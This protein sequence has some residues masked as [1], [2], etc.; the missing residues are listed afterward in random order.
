MSAVNDRT[1]V[2]AVKTQNGACRGP[3]SIYPVARRLYSHSA[4]RM[5]TRGSLSSVPATP[6]PAAACYIGARDAVTYYW[7]TVCQ[8]LLLVAPLLTPSRGSSSRS[9]VGRGR[10]P[11]RPAPPSAAALPPS[12]PGCPPPPPTCFRTRPRCGRTSPHARRAC[13]SSRRR[14]SPQVSSWMRASSSSISAF[15]S[16]SASSL[17]SR[18]SL[19]GLAGFAHQPRDNLRKRQ[20]ARQAVERRRAEGGAMSIGKWLARWWE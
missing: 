15:S 11:G 5:R 13:S 10:G 6:R 12:T 4:A 20:R 17:R 19:G 8:A 9:A 7:S 16:I 18:S 14:V 2:N 3:T 1:A